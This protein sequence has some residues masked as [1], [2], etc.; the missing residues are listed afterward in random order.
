MII[1]FNCDVGSVKGLTR[2]SSLIKSLLH[3]LSAGE[4]MAAWQS[5][6][7]LSLLALPLTQLQSLH[8]LQ[9]GDLDEVL[10]LLQK[11]EGLIKMNEGNIR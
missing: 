7:L 10:L 6:L 1:F 3:P 4:V 9:A 11:L 5:C 2:L 8:Q